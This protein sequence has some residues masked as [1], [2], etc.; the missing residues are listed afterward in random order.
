M[1]NKA[2]FCYMLTI[3]MAIKKRITGMLFILLSI[4]QVSGQ[5]LLLQEIAFGK[6]YFS[7]GDSLYMPSLTQEDQQLIVFLFHAEQDTIGLDPGLSIQGRY[8][9]IKLLNLM[10]NIPFAAYYTTPFRNNILTLQPLVDRNKAEIQYYDQAD[11]KA[12]VK[13]LNTCFLSRSSSWFILKQSVILFINLPEDLLTL[14]LTGTKLI[15]CFSL[16]EAGIKRQV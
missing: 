13:K 4:Y 3:G 10:K 8:R 1:F 9:A 15:N 2:Y 12:L 5:E 11:I 7:N 16:N 6:F 14:I